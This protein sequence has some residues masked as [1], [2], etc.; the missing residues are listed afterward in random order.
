[1]DSDSEEE[2]PDWN[3]FWTYNPSADNP[4]E[5]EECME[6]WHDYVWKK[7]QKKSIKGKERMF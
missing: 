5:F 3:R 7:E 1:M 6:D 4:H 2:N